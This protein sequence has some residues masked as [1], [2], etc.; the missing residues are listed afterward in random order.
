MNRIEALDTL[1]S[2]G[3]GLRPDY[4]GVERLLERAARHEEAE[5]LRAVMV[6]AGGRL[7]LDSWAD[8]ESERC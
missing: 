2:M 6:E 8:E 7:L 4:D 5:M 1:R 3:H